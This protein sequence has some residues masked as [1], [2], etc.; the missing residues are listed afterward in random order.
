MAVTGLT[1]TQADALGIKVKSVTISSLTKAHYMPESDKI[2]VKVVFKE[3]G[4]LVG[5]QLM[6]R[7]V[8]RVNIFATAIKG[9]MNLI[10]MAGIDL[11]YSPPFAP[12]WDPVLI[13]V[14][15]AL[16]EVK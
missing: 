10:D 4:E 2:V 13:A 12:V 16:K 3:N 5:A 15:Q 11:A 7:G 6:G 8:E 14:N 9:K 1:E